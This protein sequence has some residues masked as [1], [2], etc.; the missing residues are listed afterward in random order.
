MANDPICGRRL[1]RGAFRSWHRPVAVCFEKGE[2]VATT[3][4][5]TFDGASGTRGRPAGNGSSHRL[6]GSGGEGEFI[7]RMP[8][9][10]R[11]VRSEPA[12]ALGQQARCSGPVGRSPWEPRRIDLVCRRAAVEFGEAGE[13]SVE[14]DP[15]RSRTLSQALPDRRRSRYCRPR[16]SAGRGR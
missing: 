12:S 4:S 5:G 1:L 2:D 11:G 10:F 15:T 3:R 16:Q 6:S 8:A 9:R 7:A 13:V 14:A